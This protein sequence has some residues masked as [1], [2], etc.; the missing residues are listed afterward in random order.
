MLDPKRLP[1]K[2]L[3][4]IRHSKPDI[5][6]VVYQ[7]ESLD[8]DGYL[9]DKVWIYG[10]QGDDGVLYD[11]CIDEERSHGQ[12]PVGLAPPIL[13]FVSVD[14]SPTKFWALTWMLY[15]PELNLFHIIDIERTKL[16]AEDLLGY[17][18][19]TGE[20][21][22]IMEEWQER[23][24]RMG[25]PISHWIVEINA[26]QRFLLA[27]DFVRK[28]ASRNSLNV[29]PHTTHRNKLDEKLGVE[30]LLPSLFRHG[31]IRLPNNR[32]TWKTMA[33]V[34]ELTSWTTDKK[35]GTDIV[36]SIWMGV[37]NAPN[38]SELRAPPL[39]WRPS[40]MRR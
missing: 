18:T 16:T 26:A 29:L 19:T 32:T 20:Y 6:R 13:S 5:F 31:N 15:Q 7:Q 38:I 25:Y 22:G 37:L 39:Q 17:N 11:G 35:N 21:T 8:L 33:A 12:I 9:I 34:Q 1:W 10:G 4:F 14:P 30:A 3:S 27:H 28:W 23:S 2:D 36:M 40:W 24:Y